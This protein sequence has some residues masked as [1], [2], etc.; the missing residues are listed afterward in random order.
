VQ[1]AGTPKLAE[2]EINERVQDR[3]VVETEKQQDME[4]II[5]CS[6][7]ARLKRDGDDNR[8]D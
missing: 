1:I 8:I 4:G 6:S 5:W 3:G 7:K 2:S